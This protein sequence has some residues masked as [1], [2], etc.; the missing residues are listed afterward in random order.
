[1]SKDFCL[2][3]EP[4][5]PVRIADGQ[6]VELGL[7]EVFARSGEIIAL[8]DTGPTNLVA[9]Y[10][11]LLAVT[12]R[13]LTT[14]LGKWSNKERAGWF[15]KG[16]PLEA[17]RGYLESWRERFWLFHEEYP[18]MQVAVL[19]SAEETRDKR[20]PWTQIA[21][22]SASGNT[23]MVF[24]HACDLSPQAI[25]SA[26]AITTLLGFLQFTPGGLVKTLRD[27]D[28]AGALVNT[29]A[30]IPVGK[31]LAQTLCLALHPA[32][33]NITDPDLPAW[34]RDPVSIAALR[35]DPIPAS[36]P[37]DRYTRLS[38]AVL[39]RREEDGSIR[40]LHF[41][42]GLALGEDI[43]A[44]DPMA[45]FR[46]GSNGLVRLTFNEGRALWRD[47]SALLPESGAGGRA[48][49]VVQ[50][51]VALH[52]LLDP[53]EVVYQ[54]LLVAGLASDQAKLLRWRMEQINLPSVLLLEPERIQYLRLLLKTADDLFIEIK[55]LAVGMVA[56]T[57][58]DPASKDTRAR[59]RSQLEAG[60]LASSY[61][62]AAGR[63]LPE[64]LDL[65]GNPQAEEADALWRKV[66]RHASLEAWSQVLAGLGA[67]ALALKA[68]A[69]YWPRFHG[70]LNK[71]VPL[72]TSAT[73]DKEPVS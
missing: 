39:L 32:A 19:A 10:R 34:E 66:L 55:R 63:L 52:Q 43:Q 5:L 54:P 59:A 58:P 35:G 56:A 57:L 18:F 1:M 28:K 11:L 46:E 62:A 7:L 24:D 40:W 60:P 73:L 37:N 51:A 15:R 61:F 65:I 8:A 20:K 64:L 13:A 31:T 72:P 47:L 16:L 4:W 29:A 71:H 6:V 44:P 36:G 2:L 69:R 3:D 45:T 21:L 68:D 23:P 22:A 49:A 25:S 42:A 27:A 12:H 50:S 67:S 14:T 70:L 41:A 30:T 33:S 26:M 48:A 17:V 38:R 53:F 9:H